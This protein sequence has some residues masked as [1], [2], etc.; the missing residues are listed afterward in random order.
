ML[1]V[2]LTDDC[3]HR[4]VYL[5]IFR[6]LGPAFG[7]NLKERPRA[8]PLWLGVEK[9]AKGVDAI[10][11]ALR[12]VEA[13][14]PEDQTPAPETVAQP[15]RQARSHGIARGLRIGRGIDTDGKR[16]NAHIAAFE[17]EGF[18]GRSCDA[19]PD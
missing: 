8:P 6:H 19:V 2:D 5:D 14:N 9:V 1:P 15:C 13:I 12:I 3:T 7:S 16:A 17:F 4:A 10:G 18:A 11:D